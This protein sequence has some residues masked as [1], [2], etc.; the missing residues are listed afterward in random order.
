MFAQL[1][2]GNDT[3]IEVRVMSLLTGE[4]NWLDSPVRGD[5]SLTPNQG[6]TFY[7]IMI[8]QN[9]LRYTDSGANTAGKLLPICCYSQAMG[10]TIVTAEF[11]VI[12]G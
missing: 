4:F 9:K 7:C 8:S 1:V 11:L 2:A 3:E 12:T 5:W 6:I 10:Q